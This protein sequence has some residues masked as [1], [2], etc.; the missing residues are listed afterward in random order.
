MATCTATTAA[1][2]SAH[3][4]VASPRR[5]LEMD[6]T[7]LWLYQTLA[8]RSTQRATNL[9]PEVVE[10]ARVKIDAVV[11]QEQRPRGGQQTEVTDIRVSLKFAC[12]L[13]KA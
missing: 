12:G 7:D 9:G 2:I 3:A 13:A 8:R 4:D 6:S 11:H 5:T 1:E 10:L